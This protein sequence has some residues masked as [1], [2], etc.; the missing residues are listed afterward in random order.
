MKPDK[1]IDVSRG[2]KMLSE[3]LKDETINRILLVSFHGCGDQ[4]MVLPVFKRIQELYPNKHFDLGLCKGL[5]QEEIYS[6]AILL[7]PDW[8]EKFD[9]LGYD[10]VFSWNMPMSET[11][12][13][14]TK[15]E[16]SCKK[17]LGIEPCCGHYKPDIIKNRLVGIH[18]FITC[19]PDLA[20][21]P[22]EVAKKVWTEVKD[23]GFIPISVHFCHVFN[24]PVNSKHDFVDRH[25]RDI[26]PQISTLAGLIQSCGFFIGGVSG[27]FHV[28]L[29][30]LPPER[31]C[32]MEKEFL[33]PS[34]TRLPI[35][36]VNVKEYKDNT[37]KEWLLKN[38]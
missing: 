17:E 22:Y 13:E 30:V 12:T 23:V 32:L 35:M 21:T 3:Y 34:F 27:P 26:K 33:A 29:T 11:Q 5:G 18:Q 15:G 36:R 31:I 28:A 7:N 2:D 19:L 9:T 8:R 24:N 1:V 38:D 10:L 4:C 6:K 20:N 14:F 37:I 16:W 25:V